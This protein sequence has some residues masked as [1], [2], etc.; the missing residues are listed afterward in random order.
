MSTF[1]GE[2]GWSSDS[3][4]LGYLDSAHASKVLGSPQFAQSQADLELSRSAR[5]HVSCMQDPQESEVFLPSCV[6]ERF[7][8][9][10]ALH[11]VLLDV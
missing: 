1:A 7:M 11:C 8:R 6:I 5:C 4:K 2:D 3:Q 9:G 10:L